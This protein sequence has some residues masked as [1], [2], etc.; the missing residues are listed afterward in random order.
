MKTIVFDLD[1][2]LVDSLADIIH[3]FRRGFEVYGLP[4]PTEDEVRPEIGKPLEM[5]YEVFAPSHVRELCLAY[6]SYYPEHWDHSSL[7]PGVRELLLELRRRGYRS[8]VAT[9]KMTAMAKGLA[10]AVGL[11]ELVDYIQGTDGFPPKPAPD[12]VFKA[13]AGAGGEGLWMVGDTTLDVLAGKAAGLKTY[14]VSWGTHGKE[15]L[16]SARPDIL[17]PDLSLLL[18]ELSPSSEL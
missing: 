6:R 12:V 2:T 11:S 3:S 15:A 14:A 13:I 4:V 9:T 17:A 1:G 16:A 18:E 10:G 7:Y 8:A 5:M